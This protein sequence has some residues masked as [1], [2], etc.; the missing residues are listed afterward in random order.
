MIIR[1]GQKVLL[2]IKW[3]GLALYYLFYY[4]MFGV[5]SIYQKELIDVLKK[6]FSPEMTRG[7]YHEPLNISILISHVS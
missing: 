7:F 4:V 5:F 6:F 3:R 2:S 1:P